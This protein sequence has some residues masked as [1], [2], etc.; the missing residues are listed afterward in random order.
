MQYDSYFNSDLK[1][2]PASPSLCKII[3]NNIK[4]N[5]LSYMEDTEKYLNSILEKR[6]GSVPNHAYFS[7]NAN[8]VTRLPK[9]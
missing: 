8:T 6:L 3:L 2:T 7:K 5:L 1:I 4:A 9:K